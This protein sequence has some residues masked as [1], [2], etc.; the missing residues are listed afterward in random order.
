MAQDTSL[1]ILYFYTQVQAK[2]NVVEDDV[3]SEFC[4]TIGVANIREYEEKQLQQQQEKTQ[5]RLDFEKQKGRLTS[6]LEYVKSHDHVQQHKK[7]LLIH[8][9]TTLNHPNE[10]QSLILP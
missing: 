4:K 3:F 7:V 2:K 5:K 10:I 1:F 8:S 9:F 6:Q